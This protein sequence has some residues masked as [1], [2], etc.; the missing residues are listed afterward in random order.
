MG[1]SAIA[2][3]GFGLDIGGPRAWRLREVDEYGDITA[4]WSGTFRDVNGEQLDVVDTMLLQ[5]YSR[6]P[7]VTTVR[8]QNFMHADSVHRHYGI[9]FV[10][11]GRSE[12]RCGYLLVTDCVEAFHA[13]ARRVGELIAQPREPLVAKIEAALN[14][15]GLTPAED[16]APDWILVPWWSC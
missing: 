7:G 6:I 15:L 11:Y 16:V 3:L 4:P 5:L 1:V 2:F 9:S 14:I 13:R 12:G 10:P 8:A